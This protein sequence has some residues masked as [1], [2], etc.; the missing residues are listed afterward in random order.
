M[1]KGVIEREYGL[2]QQHTDLLLTWPY[3]DGE[4]IQQVVLELKLR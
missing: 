2:G 1:M 4:C 3:Q